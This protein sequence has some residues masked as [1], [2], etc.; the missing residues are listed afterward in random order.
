MA[1]DG[2]YA[3]SPVSD[4]RVIYIDVNPDRDPTPGLHALDL[5]T[6]EIVWSASPP[7]DAYE[8]KQGCSH[9]NSAGAA[10]IP[11]V[12]FAGGLDG[13]IRAYAADDRRILWDF[14]TTG[15][16]ETSSG[17]SG[18]GGAIDGPGPVFAGGML[19]TNNGYSLFRQ[20]PGSLLLAF[21]LR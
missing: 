21:G 8:G 11:R 12:V 20:M 15:V 9:A 4:R 10:A 18:L 6:C 5:M 19:F 1:T 2:R 17:V 3:Y 14:D 7:D 13:H 16:T